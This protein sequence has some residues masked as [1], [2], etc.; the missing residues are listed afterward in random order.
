MSEKYKI[1]MSIDESHVKTR[2]VNI[3][4][5][6]ELRYASF[7]LSCY[8]LCFRQLDNSMVTL[9]YPLIENRNMLHNFLTML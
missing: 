8:R 6:K 2:I 5:F 9:S 3:E 7:N 4:L 1:K